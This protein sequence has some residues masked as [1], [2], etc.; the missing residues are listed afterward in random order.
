MIRMDDD[1]YKYLHDMENNKRRYCDVRIESLS[2]LWTL[3]FGI[4]KS[5]INWP[6]IN[7]HPSWNVAAHGRLLG[8][9]WYT[10]IQPSHTAVPSQWNGCVPILGVHIPFISKIH[11]KAYSRT[12]DCVQSHISISR[13]K[14]PALC[15]SSINRGP[16]TVNV[17]WI[18]V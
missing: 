16:N 14:C 1:G 11:K 8:T 9:I 15:C 3:S 17:H 6:L 13:V 12:T 10:P 2:C 4:E 5:I 18:C 7:T